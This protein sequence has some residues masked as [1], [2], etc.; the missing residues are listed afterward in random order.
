MNVF[1]T[2]LITALS[3][4]APMVAA[5]TGSLDPL[6]ISSY[7]SH[8][9]N[10]SVMLTVARAGDELFMAGERGIV[11]R[12]SGDGQW[13]QDQV[14]VSTSITRIKPVSNG[15]LALGHSGTVLLLA[16]V[17][18]SRWRIL[19]NGEDIPDIYQQYIDQTELSD[20]DKSMLEREV[21]SHARQGPDKPLF[22]AI[23][24]APGRVQVFGAYG[25]ALEMT[26]S[27]QDVHIQPITHR[28]EENEYMHLYGAAHHGDAI[29]VVGEQ[30]TLYRSDDAGLS[31]VRQ[32][33]PYPGSFF[34]V[35]EAQGALYIYGMKGHLYR[36][37]NEGNWELVN[38]PTEAA[39]ADISTSDDNQLYVLTQSGQV[40]SGCD[41]RCEP[42]GRVNAPAAGMALKGD[43]IYLSTFAGP[44]SLQ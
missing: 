19:I 15:L 5:A 13:S 21:A 32:E 8:R 34:G 43:R 44:Q 38:I 20:P 40:F 10:S 29:Y 7:V 18:Q 16:D 24:V 3:G 22:D 36:Q 28:F 4:L 37:L 17:S 27:G 35:T 33:S 23:E 25:L 12:S 26:F 11:M 39:I 41:T 9:L 6:D 1:K 30:G 14:P 2:L 31:Y 42:N